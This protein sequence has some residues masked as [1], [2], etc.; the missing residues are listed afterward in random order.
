MSVPFWFKDIKILFDKNNLVDFW[1]SKFQSFEERINSLTR[2]ILYSGL[3]I[4]VYKNDS[5]AFVLSILLVAT[6]AMMTKNSKKVMKSF[7]EQNNCHLPSKNNPLANRIPYDDIERLQ[8]CDSSSVQG[9]ITDTLFQQFPTKNLSPFNKN[10]QERQFFSMP[11]T[12]IV[13][14]QKGFASWLYG[15]PNRKMCKSNPEVCTGGEGMI[16]GA[17][18]N[19]SNN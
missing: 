7:L 16:N 3:I 15:D 2:F 4:S 9:H 5:N 6:L 12:D 10:M 8:A 11:N 13:N 17:S 14:D 1:P 18:S 19:G